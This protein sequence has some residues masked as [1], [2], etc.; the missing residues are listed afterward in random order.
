M[1]SF[2]QARSRKSKARDSKTFEK[3]I[4]GVHVSI[5]SLFVLFSENMKKQRPAGAEQEQETLKCS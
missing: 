2:H 4:S 1:L 5:I 3:N